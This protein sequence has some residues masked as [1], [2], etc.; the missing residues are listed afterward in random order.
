M[1]WREYNN[2]NAENNTTTTSRVDGVKYKLLAFSASAPFH[3]ESCFRQIEGL[4]CVAWFPSVCPFWFSSAYCSHYPLDMSEPCQPFLLHLVCP[5][6]GHFH[7]SPNI[8]F[9]LFSI[10]LILTTKIS[11]MCFWVYDLTFVFFGVFL[12]L[13]SCQRCCALIY[14]CFL[15]FI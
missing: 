3:L 10:C 1:G 2:T 12:A 5:Y 15:N 14:W 8:F 6:R 9:T 4:L 7:G 11:G 13:E